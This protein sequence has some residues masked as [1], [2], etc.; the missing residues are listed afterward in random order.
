MRV[1]TLGPPPRVHY[2]LSFTLTGGR[3]TACGISHT[4]V[5]EVQEGGIM[6]E[7]SEGGFFR[8]HP[9]K[10]VALA[11]AIISLVATLIKVFTS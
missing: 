7:G 6:Q 11:T 9:E 1:H 8:N 5:G 2:G 4:A 3:I 10:L